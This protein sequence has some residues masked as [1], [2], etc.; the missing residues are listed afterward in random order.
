MERIL[1]SSA[2]RAK[3]DELVELGYT[4]IP[5]LLQDRLLGERPDPPSAER[6]TFR[7]LDTV[8]VRPP[9]VHMDFCWTT[10]H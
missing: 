2:A 6:D 9:R 3:R 10:L 5:G 4:I 7:H 1:S 8:V